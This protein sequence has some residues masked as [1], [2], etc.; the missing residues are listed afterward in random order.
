MFMPTY[1]YAGRY[2]GTM[3]LKDR[4]LLTW[5]VLVVVEKPFVKTSAAADKLIELAK[6]KGKILTVFHSTSKTLT[7]YM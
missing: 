7:T 3:Y 1:M 4:D 2:V 6:A 5:L